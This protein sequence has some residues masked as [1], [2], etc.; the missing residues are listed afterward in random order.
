M[1]KYEMERIKDGD[2]DKDLETEEETTQ[3]GE[4]EEEEMCEENEKQDNER[5]EEARSGI[6]MTAKK[7][8]VAVG[9]RGGEEDS[10]QRKRGKE[11]EAHK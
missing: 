6:R 7:G 8:R 2:G 5:K 10:D 9:G 11:D 4:R 3:E 1:Q